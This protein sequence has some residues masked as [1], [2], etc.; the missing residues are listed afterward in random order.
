MPDHSKVIALLQE[1]D[2][3]VAGSIVEDSGA[4]G[5]LFVH[6]AVV[7]DS[8]NKQAPSNRKLNDARH[9]LAEEGITVEFLLTDGQQQDIEAG[10][11]A[12]VLHAF[13]SNVR[14]VFMSIAD[15]SAQVWLDPKQMLNEAVSKAIAEKVETYISGFNMEL[16]SLALTTGENL[17]S[18]LACLRAVRQLAPVDSSELL[19][20]LVNRGFT[21]PSTDWLRRRLDIMRK[22]GQIV[23]LEGNLYVLSLASI[24]SLGTIKGRASPD[25]TRMLALARREM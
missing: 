15:G 14:N 2:I 18:T 10:L 23:R 1:M 17:P 8:K 13:G 6:V 11:R 25:V 9:A 7:R 16:G 20:E 4:P 22:K 21:V 3:D 19:R 12:T 5:R 24:R